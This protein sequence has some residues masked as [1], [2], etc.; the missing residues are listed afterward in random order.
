MSLGVKGLKSQE[1]QIPG[2]GFKTSWGK[3][4]QCD[5]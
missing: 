3:F 1:S 2:C 5:K 4:T